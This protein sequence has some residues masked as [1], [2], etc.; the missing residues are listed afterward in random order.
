MLLLVGVLCF[1]AL[2]QS[3]G[4]L[5]VYNNYTGLTSKGLWDNTLCM[6]YRKLHTRRIE[7]SSLLHSSVVQPVFIACIHWFIKSPIRSFL[8]IFFKLGPNIAL[9][10][11]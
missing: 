10:R 6:L 7:S 3:R 8:E 9:V 4:F 11:P 5:D 1:A 2:T